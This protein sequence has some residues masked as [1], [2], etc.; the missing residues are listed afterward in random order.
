MAWVSLLEGDSY[1]RLQTVFE[2]S[3][4][5]AGTAVHVCGFRRCCRSS[6]EVVFFFRD[7][8]H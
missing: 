5:E 4:L 7:G 8:S 2:V 1:R 3:S 6:V